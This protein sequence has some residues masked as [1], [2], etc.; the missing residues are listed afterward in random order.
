MY[1][2]KHVYI[3]ALS[4]V[5]HWYNWISDGGGY[6]TD[7]VWNLQQW[8]SCLSGIAHAHTVA[9]ISHSW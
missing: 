8:R 3:V 2:M 6:R 1:R 9:T 7:A 4:G 5:P